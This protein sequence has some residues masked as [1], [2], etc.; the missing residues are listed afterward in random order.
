MVFITIVT[1]TYK[2]TNISWGPHIVY[3]VVTPVPMG[4]H[5]KKTSSLHIPDLD[6]VFLAAFDQGSHVMSRT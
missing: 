1:G 3:L 5:K 4:P 2:P 6:M